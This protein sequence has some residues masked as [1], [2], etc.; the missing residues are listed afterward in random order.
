MLNV[1]AP[2]GRRYLPGA[3]SYEV[4][5]LCCPLAAEIARWRTL[6]FDRATR[7]VRALSDQQSARSTLPLASTCAQDRLGFL[8]R[9]WFWIG[10]PNAWPHRRT[11]GIDRPLTLTRSC[12]P[13]PLIGSLRFPGG[14]S[15]SKRTH[16]DAQ[17]TLRRPTARIFLRMRPGGATFAQC[18]A[19]VA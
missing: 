11:A 16:M 1:R 17:C 12:L 6:A 2:L 4:D 8:S 3:A 14:G 7:A 15:L 13:A 19:S 10:R 9:F 5:R 18:R